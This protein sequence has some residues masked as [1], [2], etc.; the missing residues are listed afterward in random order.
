M[1]RKEPNPTVMY[2]KRSFKHIQ[3]I[4]PGPLD[5]DRIEFRIMER[6]G[7]KVLKF[8]N[9][10]GLLRKYRP[11]HVRIVAQKMIAVS[12]SSASEPQTYALEQVFEL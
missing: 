1:K 10:L 2:I 8:F 3:I 7:L 6:I 12:F 9:H 11:I 5:G 4:Q